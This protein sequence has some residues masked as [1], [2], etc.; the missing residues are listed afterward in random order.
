M[1]GVLDRASFLADA[2]EH[3]EAHKISQERASKDA[4]QKAAAPAVNSWLKHFTAL[5]A[6]PHKYHPGLPSDFNELSKGR[7]KLFSKC[8]LLQTVVYYLV[9]L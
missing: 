6:N 8:A 4:A 9:P 5:R 7:Q 2:H 1:I 3:E